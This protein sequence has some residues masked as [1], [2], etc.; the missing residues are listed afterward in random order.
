MKFG[1]VIKSEELE[2][3][4]EGI[5]GV[6]RRETINK[7]KCIPQPYGCG[8]DVQARISIQR[9]DIEKG[10]FRDELS[11]REYRISGLC[12]LCQDKIFGGP[13]D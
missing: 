3:D 6:D 11:V 1:P 4:L 13:E 12:Q 10:A 2:K 7:L 8:R 5:F 9:E